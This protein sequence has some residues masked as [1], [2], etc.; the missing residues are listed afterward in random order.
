VDVGVQANFVDAKPS[1]EAATKEAADDI[2]M[3]EAE[4]VGDP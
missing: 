2:K 1:Q 3:K 4:K